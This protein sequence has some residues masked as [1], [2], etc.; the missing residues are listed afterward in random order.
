MITTTRRETVMT[1]VEGPRRRRPAAARDLDEV[2]ELAPGADGGDLRL[3]TS[4]QDVVRRLV[5]TRGAGG[6]RFEIG[7]Q[8]TD[9]Q[10]RYRL[11]GALVHSTLAI[12]AP[13]GVYES[14]RIFDQTRRLLADVALTRS[15]RRAVAVAAL[16]QVMAYGRFFHEPEL[17]FVGAEVTLDPGSR[18]DLVWRLPD[19]RMLVDEVK[20]GAPPGIKWLP[21]DQVRRYLDVARVKW[22]RGFYGLRVCWLRAP[23]LSA[24][25]DSSGR[26][27]VNGP[28]VMAGVVERAVK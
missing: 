20:T 14:E 19:G 18:C 5:A 28:R 27:L 2:I 22:G 11:I 25:L 15:A 6:G 24:T 13:D 23:G 7:H 8:R 21:S 10:S 4:A 16:T 17:R 26:R 12:L 1:D 3:V 9:H